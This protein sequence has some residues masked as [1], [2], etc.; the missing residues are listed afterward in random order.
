MM[1]TGNVYPR[2]ANNLASL[3]TII[4]KYLVKEFREETECLLDVKNENKYSSWQYI[5]SLLSKQNSSGFKLT[6]LFSKTKG[7]PLI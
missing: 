1:S 5:V 7:L 3:Q 2:Q 6:S 4:L